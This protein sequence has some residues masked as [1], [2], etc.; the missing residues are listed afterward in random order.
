[1]LKDGLV[2]MFISSFM[3]LFPVANPIGAGFVLN[4]FL[5]GLGP[6]DRKYVIRKIV[7]DYLIVGLG[8]LAV[9]H[10]ILLLFGLSLPIIQIG[11]GLLICKTALQWLSDSDWAV[12][13]SAGG[14]GVK[15][16]GVGSLESR[17]FYPMT[18]PISIGPGSVSVIL[19]LVASA[20]VKG[21]FMKSLANY[22]VIALVIGAM[23][24]IL[25]LFLTQGQRILH[26]IGDKG[27]LVINKMVA[28]FTFCVGIQIVVAGITKVFHLN[29]L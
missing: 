22:A 25:Y 16:V 19:T 8:S 20:G 13:R 4:G 29:V 7:I 10:F 23:C 28:F 3:A 17:I 14:D 21:P 12:S 27:S 26:K 15:N 9:G 24:L 2:F 18:F 5:I 11:G 6:Q 1:M